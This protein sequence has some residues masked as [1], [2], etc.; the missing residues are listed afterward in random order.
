MLCS[1]CRFQNGYDWTAGGKLPG[2]CSE[3]APKKTKTNL[4]S[5]SRQP[6][7]EFTASAL[8]LAASQPMEARARDTLTILN[9]GL[10]V[11][12]A[13]NSARLGARRGVHWPPVHPHELPNYS[14]CHT[15][16]CMISSR[17]ISRQSASQ[18]HQH[19]P[20]LFSCECVA[21]LMCHWMHLPC[22]SARS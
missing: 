19:R 21:W 4:Q 9:D 15:Y 3:G 13:C 8:S 12:L 2:M 7:R 6:P 11:I 20:C 18:D 17:T 14:L 16:I 22:N 10:C 5:G 1:L